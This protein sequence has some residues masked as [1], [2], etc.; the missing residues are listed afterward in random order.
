MR[1]HC[2]R[3]AI[4]VMTALV[5]AACDSGNKSS[6]SPNGSVG[7]VVEVEEV[8]ML[9]GNTFEGARFTLTMPEGWFEGSSCQPDDFCAEIY[10][11]A[12]NAKSAVYAHPYFELTDAAE[13][14]KQIANVEE[15]SDVILGDYTWKFTVYE[16]M[17]GATIYLTTEMP[18]KGVMFVRVVNAELTDPGVQTMLRSLKLLPPND[19]EAMQE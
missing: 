16:G 12:I 10:N 2:F 11:E 7:R 15:V 18:E 4:V 17:F 13:T 8:D 14:L 9:S 3:F 1:T 6:Q 19:A 5:M